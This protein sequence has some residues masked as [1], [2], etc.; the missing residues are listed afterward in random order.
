MVSYLDIDHNSNENF[1]F[2]HFFFN[3]TDTNK[4]KLANYY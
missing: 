4:L 3:L 2:I 1:N